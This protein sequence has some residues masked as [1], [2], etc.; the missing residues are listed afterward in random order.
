MIPNA[1]GFLNRLS[2]VKLPRPR[3]LFSRFGNVNLRSV[4]V[5][6]GTPLLAQ[7]K[8]DLCDEI[9]SEAANYKAPETLPEEKIE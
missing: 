8:N 6:D 5:A 9:N 3:D 7:R 1:E 4:Q 2:I